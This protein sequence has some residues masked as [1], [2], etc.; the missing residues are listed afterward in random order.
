MA[1]ENFK[2]YGVKITG[3]CIYE[4]KNKIYSFLLLHPSKTLPQVLIITHFPQEEFFE[5]LSPSRKW[6]NRES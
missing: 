4:S 3:K 1:R 6:G 5:N 2:I